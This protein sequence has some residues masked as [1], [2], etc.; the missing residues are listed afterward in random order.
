MW[1]SFT[2]KKKYYKE[3]LNKENEQKTCIGNFIVPCKKIYVRYNNNPGHCRIFTPTRILNRQ[4]D[5]FIKCGKKFLE[6]DHH[7]AEI[8]H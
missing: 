4:T 6:R 3:I 2:L 1:I 7:E 5:K 8:F